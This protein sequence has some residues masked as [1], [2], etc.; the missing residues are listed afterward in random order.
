MRRT[1]HW[2]PRLGRGLLLGV[3]AVVL[4]AMLGFYVT[5]PVNKVAVMANAPTSSNP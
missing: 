1:G 2:D 3:A 5:G 4:I